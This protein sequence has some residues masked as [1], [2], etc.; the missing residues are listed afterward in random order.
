MRSPSPSR[1]LPWLAAALVL[2]VPAIAGADDGTFQSYEQR[3]YIWMY[4]AAFGF[5]FLTSLTPCVY[6]MVPIT[7]SIFGARGGNVSKKKAG[8]SVSSGRSDMRGSSC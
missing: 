1:L 6:P 8:S 4:L 7:L 5:G 2:F 3:G